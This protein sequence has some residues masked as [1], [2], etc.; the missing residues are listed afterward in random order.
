ML[1]FHKADYPHF[2]PDTI[3]LNSVINAWANSRDFSAGRRAEAIM[4]QQL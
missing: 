2:N 1:E 4:G 3:S